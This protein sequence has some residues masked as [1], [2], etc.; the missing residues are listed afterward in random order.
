MQKG[1]V[2]MTGTKI[3]SMKEACV[4]RLVGLNS[5]LLFLNQGTRIK[6]QFL[7]IGSHN[8]LSTNHK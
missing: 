7:A 4:R 3:Y 8:Q 1:I 6:Y 5:G 2:K